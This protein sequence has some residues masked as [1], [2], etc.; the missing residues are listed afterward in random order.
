MELSRENINVN[1]ERLLVIEA[2]SLLNK[3]FYASAQQLKFVKTEEQIQA[4]YDKLRKAE[5]GTY[6]NGIYIL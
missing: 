4:V 5:D 2:S 3:S 6:T 1:T